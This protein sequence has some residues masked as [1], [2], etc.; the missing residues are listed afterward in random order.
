MIRR[1]VESV[2]RRRGWVVTL[3]IILIAILYSALSPASHSYVYLGQR[4]DRGEVNSVVTASGKVRALNTIKVGA[5]VSGQV[6]Q[7]FVDFNSRVT[8][9]QVLAEIDSTRLDARVRQARAQVALANAALVSAQATADRASGDLALQRREFT[10]R[11][12]MAKLGFL[13]KSALDIANNALAGTV[14][15]ASAANAQIASARAQIAQA[16]AEL[17][18]ADLDLSRTRIIAPATGVIID[19]LVEPGTTVV[20]SFQTP[21]LFE[22]AADTTRMQVEASVDEADIGNVR[23]AQ[24][25][26]FTV[27]SYP[28]E[29]F[30]A[31]VR[32][33]RNSAIDAQ[34]VVSYLVILDVDN[35]DGKLLPGM[36][37]TVHIVTGIRENV[38]RAPAAALRFRPRAADRSDEERSPAGAEAVYLAGADPYRPIRREVSI[39]LKGED[40]VEILRGAKVGDMLILRRQSTE[41]K[42]AE[43]PDVDAGNGDDDS[44]G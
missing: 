14:A 11:E 1:L 19:K 8:K 38:V 12:A 24:P 35:R 2:C 31:T 32:Q 4:V 40:Y 20:A 34:N 10:R 22:I 42:Q 44:V 29:I 5:E 25:V 6:T 18:A 27:D 17:G 26:S 23:E 36:T 13:S 21:T 30:R 28:Q 43:D 33:V 15:N 39:G 16:N 37:A 9:G 3:A 7:V 41:V